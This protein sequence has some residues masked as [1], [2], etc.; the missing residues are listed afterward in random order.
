MGALWTRPRL[1][2]PRSVPSVPVEVDRSHP[3]ARGLV[4]L[5]VPGCV[6]GAV[7]LCG[8]S[9]PL[10]AAGGALV[11]SAAGPAYASVAG[12]QYLGGVAGAA[13]N[14][15]AGGTLF[16]AGS[17]LGAAIGGTYDYATLVSLSYAN[18]SA[19]PYQF[20]GIQLGGSSLLFASANFNLPGST[21]AMPTGG[22]HSMA[23]TFVIG[24]AI[25]LYLDARN[26]GTGSW[27][28]G[29]PTYAAT[30]LTIGGDV[31]PFPAPGRSSNTAS[32]LAAFYDTALAP[33]EI[34]WLAQEPFGMLR[35]CG[36]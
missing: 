3:L 35:P 32:A 33:E 21:I 2:D 34:A 30:T 17:V 23:A 24:G 22:V 8:N 6:A 36:R 4:G 19:S 15:A 20:Y 12:A 26:V 29:V 13:L 31:S 16:W 10:A 11:G 25:N 5:V 14:V 9:A 1:R 28:G 18:G 7:D 27:S